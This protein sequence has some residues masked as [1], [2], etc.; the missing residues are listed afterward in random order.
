MNY[1]GICRAFTR[2]KVG[3][4]SISGI[5]REMTRPLLMVIEENLVKNG[6]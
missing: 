1:S 3:G 2:T 6:F 5:E 4:V